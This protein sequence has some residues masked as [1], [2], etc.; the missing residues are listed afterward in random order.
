MANAWLE[1]ILDAI[2]LL[3]Q[4]VIKREVVLIAIS[5]A[6]GEQSLSS[7]KSACRL[8]GKISCKLDLTTLRQD[9]LPAIFA[10]LKDSEGAVRHCMCQ[11]LHFAARAMGS[12]DVEGI[13][14][15]H[16]IE[17]SNDANAK[18]RLASLEAVIQML[19][20][21]K[22]NTCTQTVIPLVMKICERVRQDEDETLPK[23]AHHLGRICHGLMQHLSLE[24]KGWFISYFNHL[25]KIGLTP[26]PE[27]PK[28][29]TEL[30][31][32]DTQPM[33]DLLPV[34]EVERSELHAECR[35][36]CAY[37]FPAMTLFSGPEN[38]VKT[39]YPT[40]ASL[41]SDP[42]WKVR[43]TLARGLHE[44]AKLVNAEFN[45]CKMEVCGLF[46]DSHI[47]VLEAM[48]ANMVHVI[49][50]L[51]RHGVLLFA[52][53]GGQYSHGL[54]RALLNCEETISLTRNWRLQVSISTTT[55]C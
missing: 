4:E 17:L 15:P 12:E 10:L 2:D 48:V 39:L 36:Q 18:V 52:G 46:A 34:V 5:K 32:S 28:S 51:A 23:L 13:L 22:S 43:C 47:E 9:I 20:Y 11:Q 3:P 49:D 53:Q 41:A 16:L 44:V 30:T 24:Q 25:A 31:K 33:P 21:L 6:Q 38:F 50:A 37:N 1:T 14:L 19:G 35:L 27:S 54:S 40:F 26:N 29:K 7:K 45:F 8:L 42:T 55:F